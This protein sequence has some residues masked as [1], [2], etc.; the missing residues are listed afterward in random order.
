MT[1]DDYAH[2]YRCASMHREGGILE[3]RLHTDGGSLQWGKIPHSELP[4]VFEDIAH[5]PENRVIL[6]SGT[7]NE[8][9]GPKIVDADQHWVND[10]KPATPENWHHVQAEGQRLINAILSVDTPMVCAIN[11]PVRRH[12]EIPLLC[13]AIVAANTASFEDSAHF[14]P[15]MRVPGD[16]LSILLMHLMGTNR[17]RHFMITGQVLSASQAHDAGLIG[18]VVPA[19]AVSD[20]AWEIARQIA[21]KPNLTRRYT[22]QIFTR[23]LKR[24]MHDDLAH[25]FALEGLAKIELW[26]EHGP[27][28]RLQPIGS[29][30]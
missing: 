22:R 11:G 29:E 7:G 20:R 30:A 24:L 12:A 25:G 26:T 27:G 16:G 19:D 3:V 18:E 14:H 15:G 21:E 10:A 13:D 5:D 8:F 28:A 9:T 23:Q 1:F 6:I 2:K 17:A 4:C